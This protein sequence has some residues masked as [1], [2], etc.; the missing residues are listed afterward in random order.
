[1]NI[2]LLTISEVSVSL[3]LVE[4]RMEDREHALECHAWPMGASASL[5]NMDS[6]LPQQSTCKC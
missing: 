3:S 1:M 2:E 5:E 4:S 6:P